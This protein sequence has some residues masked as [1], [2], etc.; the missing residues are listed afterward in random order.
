MVAEGE[1]REDLYYRLKGVDVELPPLR[2]RRLDIPHLVRL[3]IGQ[4][5]RREGISPPVVEPDAF[6][7]L[8]TYDFPGNVRELQNLIEGAVSLAEDSVDATLVRGLLGG[9]GD[10]S[11]EPFDLQAVEQRHIRRILRLVD[12]NKSAAAK[13]LGINRRTLQRKG[14]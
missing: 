12:G 2:D 1:F 6:N 11:G 14:F 5:C 8:L 3:F 13:I 10:G 4:F 9:T 7:L